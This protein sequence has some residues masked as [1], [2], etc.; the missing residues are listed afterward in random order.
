MDYLAYHFKVTP[1]QPGSEILMAMIADLGFESFVQD[2]QGLT[3]Y[4]QAAIERQA[5]LSNLEFPDF[6]FT[7]KVERIKGRNWNQ[8]WEKNFDPVQVGDKLRIRAPF[9]EP[10]QSAA[11]DIVIM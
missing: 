11:L 2:D 10:S 8:E 9:H 7:W 4:L 5:N 6:T 1:P 3:A